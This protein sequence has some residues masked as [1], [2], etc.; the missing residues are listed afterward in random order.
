VPDSQT[1]TYTITDT[2]KTITLSPQASVSPSEVCQ[3][4]SETTTPVESGIQDKVV[5]DKVAQTITINQIKDTLAP[6]N[7][8]NDGSMSAEVTIT[9]T[10]IVTD[11]AGNTVTEPVT[12]T[13]IIKNPCIDPSF[14]YI[15]K[16][17]NFS[18]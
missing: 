3:I 9:T 6:S 15:E 13:V 5:H 14:V 11:Y 2:A 16:L 12:H 8:N 10:Y 4:D 7:P 1:L 17:A 18:P